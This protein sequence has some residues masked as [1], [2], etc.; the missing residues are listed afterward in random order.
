MESKK[1]EKHGFTR[2]TEGA[3]ASVKTLIIPFSFLSC[4]WVCRSEEKGNRISSVLIC[5]TFLQLSFLEFERARRKSNESFT[6]N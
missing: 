2:L 5:E 3:N 4:F 6:E 1:K